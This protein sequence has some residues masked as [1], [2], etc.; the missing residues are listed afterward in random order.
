[1]VAI[2]REFRLHLNRAVGTH[3]DA[4]EEAKVIH[5]SNS[6]AEP[7]GE[8]EEHEGEDCDQNERVPLA[9]DLDREAAQ[10]RRLL[11]SLHALDH[12]VAEEHGPESKAK[13]WQLSDPTYSSEHD[14]RDGAQE[15]ESE[16]VADC[17]N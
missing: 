13:L 10:T 2:E 7:H 12:E 8:L 3:L 4:G 14:H 17:A 5:V 15:P 9:L 6:E 1:M 11:G 16:E